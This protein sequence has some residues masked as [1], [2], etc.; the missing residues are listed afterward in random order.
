MGWF[1]GT[2]GLGAVNTCWTT[3]LPA[4]L[5]ALMSALGLH[6]PATAAR[7]RNHHPLPAAAAL[8]NQESLK[9]RKLGALHQALAMYRARLGLEFVHG[10]GD[11]EQLRCV[12]TQVGGRWRVAA[13]H[14]RKWVAAG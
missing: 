9:E 11:G 14:S 8:S 1:D 3:L 4:T 7:P 2:S 12:F 6:L 10:E 13:L 5:Y